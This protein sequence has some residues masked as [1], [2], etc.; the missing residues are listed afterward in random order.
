[1]NVG[2]RVRRPDAPDK[3]KGSALYVEDLAFAGSLQAGALR[4]PHAHA[5]ILRLD[6]A[7]ARGLSGVRAVLTAGT[8]ELDEEMLQTF[9]RIFFGTMSAAGE[10][11]ATATDTELAAQRVETAVGFLLSGVQSLVEN[12]GE[13]PALIRRSPG[14]GARILVPFSSNE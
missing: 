6:A 11:V 7:R 10:V 13:L 9:A 8:W 3:V 2:A 1:M 14:P 5:R 12:G 4:S